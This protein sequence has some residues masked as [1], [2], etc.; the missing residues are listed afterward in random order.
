MRMTREQRRILR[1]IF[2]S[3]AHHS[4]Y[5]WCELKREIFDRGCQSQYHWELEF[6][7]PAD[8]S[9]KSLPEPDISNLIA[10]LDK[11]TAVERL[12]N[13]C[14]QE[15]ATEYV[16]GPLAQDYFDKSLF[17]EHNINVSWFNY[18]NYAEYPQLHGEFTHN[19]SII[20]MLMMLGWNVKSFKRTTHSVF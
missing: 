14:K 5:I 15:G 9:L 4:E 19:V 20:D 13:L 1:P 12:F 18:Q 10:D 8:R 7:K 3:V 16:S 6:S 11:F 2:R 17:E